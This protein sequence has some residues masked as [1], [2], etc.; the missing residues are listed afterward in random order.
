MQANSARRHAGPATL[1]LSGRTN[2]TRG[3]VRY[4]SGAAP[5]ASPSRRLRISCRRAADGSVTLRV[6]TRSPRTKLRKVVGKRLVVGLYRD[7]D[8]P[9]TANVQATFNR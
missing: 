7:Q 9:G 3:T 5:A 6:R 4:S 8:A 1:S 2:R